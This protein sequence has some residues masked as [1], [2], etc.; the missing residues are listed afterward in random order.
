[1]KHD[2]IE[3]LRFAARERDLR[4][5]RQ[6]LPDDGTG[7]EDAL[8]LVEAELRAAEEMRALATPTPRE[9]TDCTA[10]NATRAYDAARARRKGL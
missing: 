8:A 7:T 4:R 2:A 9:H 10:C 3:V 5:L 6:G 1:V